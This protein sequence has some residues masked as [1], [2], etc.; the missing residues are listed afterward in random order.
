MSTSPCRAS[1]AR[2]ARGA[3]T[4]LAAAD[5]ATSFIWAVA[6]LPDVQRNLA[7]TG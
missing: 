5:K 2:S 4:L 1:G 7:S 6:S 3:S